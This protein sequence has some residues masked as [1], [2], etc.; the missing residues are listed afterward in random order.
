MGTATVIARNIRI[1]RE[2]ADLTQK[3]LADSL[4]LASH[5][6][7]SDMESGSRRVSAGDLAG[8]AKA[9]G[10]TLD[11]F[12]DP[13][14]GTEDFVVLARAQREASETRAELRKA[15]RLAENY[16]FL[17]RVLARRRG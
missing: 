15:E 7:V 2:E 14:A 8:I 4:G 11:Y 6:A 10:K 12:F 16:V 1:A 13:D 17:K 5:S 9:T 3:A